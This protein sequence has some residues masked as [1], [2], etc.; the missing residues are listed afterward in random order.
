MEIFGLPLDTT[1]IAAGISG[2]SGL[3]TGYFG[4]KMKEQDSVTKM[5]E[6]IQENYL[7]LKREMRQQEAECEKQHLAHKKECDKRITHLEK[8]IDKLKLK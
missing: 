3:L 2:F 8:E 4:K 6:M 5:S 7:E 1:L